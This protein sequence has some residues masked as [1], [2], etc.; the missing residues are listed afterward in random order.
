MIFTNNGTR[1]TATPII[2][3][4][5]NVFCAFFISSSLPATTA[6]KKSSDPKTIRI[7]GTAYLGY[8]KKSFNNFWV[9]ESIN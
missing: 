2:T 8:F 4:F 9:L 1:N 3:L 6:L 5:I 7:A